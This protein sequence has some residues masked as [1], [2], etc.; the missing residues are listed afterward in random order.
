M[1]DFNPETVAIECTQVETAYQ[2]TLG[3]PII[4]GV[5][6]TIKAGE[7]V[8]LLGSN[9]AGKS[10]LLRSL[11]G[12]NPIQEGAIKVNGVKVTPKTLPLIRKQMSMLF[13]SGGLIPQLSALDNVLCGRLGS[14]PAWQTLFGFSKRDRSLALDLLARLELKEQSQQKTSRLSGGERQRVA[15]ARMLMQSPSILLADEPTT[16]LDVTAIS[17]VMDILSKL[18]LEEGLTIVTV[19]HDLALATEYSHRAIILHQGQVT[20]DGSCH[21]LAEQFMRT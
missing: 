11:I 4:Q 6:L 7:F 21:N 5:S 15:I 20:Y 10:T 17:Q 13:Q 14:R 2:P 18:N 3:R 8:T 1:Q 9:G 12:L 19:L 16:G